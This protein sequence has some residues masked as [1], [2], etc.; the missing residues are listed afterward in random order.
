MD[1]LTVCRY[2]IPALAPS[3]TEAP[4][5]LLPLLPEPLFGGGAERRLMMFE[6]SG[7]VAVEGGAADVDA[8]YWCRAEDGGEDGMFT[9]G[10]W[11]D[12]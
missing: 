9:G 5:P 2:P 6:I 12:G 8:W 11:S 3:V 7:A 10:S 4:C 1:G